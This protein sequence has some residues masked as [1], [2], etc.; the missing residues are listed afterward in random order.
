MQLDTKSAVLHTVPHRLYLPAFLDPQVFFCKIVNHLLQTVSRFL[1]VP[2]EPYHVIHITDVSAGFR[3]LEDKAIT[4]L[5][6]EIGEVL[7]GKRAYGQ[8]LS[9]PFPIAVDYGIEERKKAAP[10]EPST[11]LLLKTTVVYIFKI[12]LNIDLD[13]PLGTPQ[14]TLHPQDGCVNPTAGKT[15][16]ARIYL[17]SLKVLADEIHDG[18][19]QHPQFKTDG[20]DLTRF[21][22][23]NPETS[24]LLQGVTGR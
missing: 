9:R 4:L 13:I 5:K 16:K 24:V 18:M 23:S 22:I 10:F 6:I 14:T 17:R 2:A 1:P 7:G 12:F 3:Q 21:W 8:S 19:V 20:D 15:G 11:K